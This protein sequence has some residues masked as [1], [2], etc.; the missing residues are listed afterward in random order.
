MDDHPAIKSIHFSGV[1]EHQELKADF[2]SGLNLVHGKNG[3]GKTTLLHILANLLEGD[4]LRFCRIRFERLNFTLGDRTV[5]VLEQ[6]SKGVVK[7]VLNGGYLGTLSQ[8]GAPVPTEIMNPIAELFPTRPVYLPAFRSI[9]EAANEREELRRYRETRELR[10][11]A[12]AIEAQEEH[13]RRARPGV[14]VRRT[15]RANVTASKTL[16]SRHWFGD[17]VPIIRY[18]SLADVSQQLAEEFQQ[19]YFEVGRTN[20]ETFSTVF[21]KVLEAV[22]SQPEP[23]T[24]EDISLLLSKVQDQ[25]NALTSGSAKGDG[26]EKTNRPT[27]P[28]NRPWRASEEQSV[29]QIL[30]IYDAALSKRAEREAAAYSRLKL[31][32]TSF[33]KYNAPKSLHVIP[34]IINT[35][36]GPR[37]YFSEDHSER[38]E[39][40]SSG[41]LQVLTMLFCETH[42]SQL[43]GIM[44]IDEPEISLHI[45]WQRIILDEIMRQAGDH[46]VIVC[47]HA[48]EVVAEHRESLVPLSSSAWSSGKILND[49]DD[50]KDESA[51]GE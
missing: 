44:L 24:T 15:E 11:E 34:Q 1:F 8:N 13:F 50:V 27:V 5:I 3:S 49:E 38:L 46:Q 36:G 32:E 45:D 37:V 17:F 10:E 25:L 33:N 30:E 31:F 42:M 22:Q 40:L 35:K 41:E 20:Q 23:R 51:E 9:L 7:V 47:T 39:V 48:P 18:P 43:Y 19:A 14:P 21:R 2:N 4:L 12:A 26:V 16:L 28:Q 6:P 29:R